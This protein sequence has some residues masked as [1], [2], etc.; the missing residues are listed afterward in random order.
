MAHLAWAVLFLAAWCSATDANRIVGGKPTTIEQHPFMVQ[1]ENWIAF[2]IWSQRCA[3]NVLTSRYVLTAASCT[4]ESLAPPQVRRIRAG[5]TYRNTG[6]SIHAVERITN[7]PSFG[8]NGFDGD[9]SIIRLETPLVYSNSIRQA[10]II[11]QGAVIPDN[12]QVVHAGWG[13]PSF[14]GSRAEYL[15]DVSVRTINNA[16]CA[17]RY[18]NWPRPHTVTSNMICAGF[19]DGAA[20]GTCFGDAGGPLIYDNMVIGIASW[21]KTCANGTYPD[22]STSVSS[23]TNWILEIAV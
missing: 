11:A 17:S 19:L 22:V 1:I 16:E 18:L 14:F 12:L 10:T 15:T 21:G 2:A 3:G 9:I 23:Y 4:R 6:G 13:R 7:H 8:Q 5:S 20:D